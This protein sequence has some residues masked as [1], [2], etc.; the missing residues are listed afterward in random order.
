MLSFCATVYIYIYI[1]IYILLIIE[2]NEDV[3]PAN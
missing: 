1:V 3:S 2:H